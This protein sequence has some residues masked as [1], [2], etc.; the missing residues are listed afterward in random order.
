MSNFNQFQNWSTEELISLI[1][2][3]GA[4][5]GE[6][7]KFPHEGDVYHIDDVYA[8]E[9]ELAKRNKINQ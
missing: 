5:K 7:D 2:S 1:A 9:D 4:D 8:A 6:G 3:A